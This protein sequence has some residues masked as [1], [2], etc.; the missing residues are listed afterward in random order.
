MASTM[1]PGALHAPQPTGEVLLPSGGGHTEL[2]LVEGINEGRDPA[3]EVIQLRDIITDLTGSDHDLSEQSRAFIRQGGSIGS[4]MQRLT[5]L[6]PEAETEA[7]QQLNET[8]E[9]YLDSLTAHYRLPLPGRKRKL[10]EATQAYTAALATRIEEVADL[11]CDSCTP[12]ELTDEVGM[13]T[14]VEGGL[15]VLASTL[16]AEQEKLNGRVEEVRK[17]TLLHRIVNSRRFYQGALAAL[18]APTTVKHTGIMPETEQV[19]HAL[20]EAEVV[21]ISLA[22][23]AFAAVQ[24]DKL[25]DR[26]SER[27]EHWRVNRNHRLL[28]LDEEI[29][30]GILMRTDETAQET[31]EKKTAA[32]LAAGLLSRHLAE[33][34]GI[35]H[36]APEDASGL[37]NELVEAITSEQVAE[38]GHSVRKVATRR[39][40]VHAL[41]LGTAVIAA[42]IVASIGESAAINRDLEETM[43]DK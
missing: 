27:I 16:V 13:N 25:L 7:I 3:L 42:P 14:V 37:Y 12:V 36:S 33:V 5:E 32:L 43:A 11:H 15:S 24:G 30:D 38:F 22:A 29:D 2:T 28:E 41:A 6:E 1:D 18:I 40:L 4:A 19:E 10:T 21:V 9:A 31:F 34:K 8:R 20:H 26:V 39:I 17:K 23:F 35:A